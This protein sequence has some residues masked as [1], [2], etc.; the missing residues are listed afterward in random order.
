[1]DLYVYIYSL[2]SSYI[3]TLKKN[4]ESD[5]V[6]RNWQDKLSEVKKKERKG[7]VPG[8]KER[9]GSVPGKK[10]PLGSNKIKNN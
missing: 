3:N 5:A 9:K 10:F 1:M 4:M 8:K 7:S 6:F 2:N